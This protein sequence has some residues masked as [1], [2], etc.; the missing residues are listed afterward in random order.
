MKTC[1]FEIVCYC[2]VCN[3]EVLEAAQVSN[4]KALLV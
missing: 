4:N 1:V 3:G 2:S